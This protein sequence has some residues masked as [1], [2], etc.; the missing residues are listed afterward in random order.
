M[1]ETEWEALCGEIVLE[2]AMN[3]SYDKLMYSE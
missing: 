1:L 2:E 3:L